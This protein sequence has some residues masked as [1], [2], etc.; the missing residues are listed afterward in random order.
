MSLLARLNAA[1]ASEGK[2]LT[3]R[4]AEFPPEDAL[5][6]ATE[7]DVAPVAVAGNKAVLAPAGTVTVAGTVR[8]GEELAREIG[9]FP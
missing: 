2:R 5:M 1:L 7:S 3:V 8:A 6:V 4:A 9:V